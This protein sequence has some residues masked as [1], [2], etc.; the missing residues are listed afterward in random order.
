MKIGVITDVHNNAVALN[1][2]LQK[3]Q[4]ENCGG[5]ICCGDMLGIG[6]YPEETISILSDIPDLMACVRGNH[7]KYLIEGMPEEVPNDENMSLNE[8]EHHKWEHNLLSENSKKFIAGLKYEELLIINKKRI[9]V[10][11]YPI[12]KNSNYIKSPKNPAL[13]DLHKM[14]EYADADVILYG[15][16]HKKSVL[17][18]DK[19]YIN[20]GSLGCPAKDKNTARAGILSIDI[21]DDISFEEITIEY[22]VTKVLDD[23]NKLNYPDNEIIKTI[24]YGIK[25]MIQ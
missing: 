8:M 11:H 22:D 18:G 6:P 9:Y 2:I 23:I 7:E 14:F 1:A 10:S 5:I 21:N 15:H 19:Y 20:C 17:R 3:F 25:E 4:A 12:D 24:F 13:D 16:N